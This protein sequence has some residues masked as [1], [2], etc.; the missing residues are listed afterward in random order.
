LEIFATAFTLR[1]SFHCNGDQSGKGHS[2]FRYRPFTLEG[3]FAAA[4]GVQEMLLQSHRGRIEVFP[5]VPDSWRDAAF[6]TLRAQGA[7]LVSAE[8]RAGVTSR[9]EI[10]AEKGGLCRIVSPWSGKE[11]VFAMKSGDQLVLTEDSPSRTTRKTKLEPDR[12]LALEILADSDLPLVLDKARALLQ[13]GLNA[14]SGYGEIWI[15]DLNTFIELALEANKSAEIRGALLTFFKFQETSGDIPD[16]FIPEE[17]GSVDYKYRKSPLAKNLLAH[18]NTVETDQESSLVQA[19][20]K[21]VTVTGDRSLVEEQVAGRRVIERLGMALDYVMTERFDPACG[22]VWGATTADWGDVQPEH[23]WGVELDDSSHRSIDIYDNAMLA[24]AIDDYLQLLDQ[25]SPNVSVWK[26]RH[27]DLKRNIR[28]HLWDTARQKFIPHLYLGGSPFPNDF[29]ESSI[30]YHGGTAVA[31]EAGILTRDEIA[32]SLGAMIEN[33]RNAGASSIGLTVYPA[34]PKGAFKNPSMGPYSYQNGGDW[35]WFGGRMIQQ[36][37]RHGLV[38]EA[39]AELKP[40]VARVRQHGDFYE[41]W[42]LDNQ[43]RGS[44]Q[45]RGSAG[46]LGKAIEQLLAWAGENAGNHTQQKKDPLP[47]TR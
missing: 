31:I 21:Y 5:A 1:N 2:K 4:A 32:R 38:R 8:Q 40:M 3:N 9:V 12:A 42:S 43:P 37:I 20:R 29:D 45:Y 46:V 24:I 16:G 35:C 27:A 14:G 22:L 36:L 28:K 25:G 26:K 33:V 6:T 34:Y 10:R 17:R 13:T 41:W 30:Y 15:R 18:K 44:K 23:K 19:V 11:L 7:F 47:F 39:Y